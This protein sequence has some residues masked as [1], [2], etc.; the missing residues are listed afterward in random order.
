MRLQAHNFCVFR[1]ILCFFFS[2]ILLLALSLSLTGQVKQMTSTAVQW[3]WLYMWYLFILFILS[4]HTLLI[5]RMY[6]TRTFNQSSNSLTECTQYSSFIFRISNNYSI[7]ITIY[8]KDTHRGNGEH[9]CKGQA[10]ERGAFVRTISDLIALQTMTDYLCC[11]ESKLQHEHGQQIALSV[12]M[13]FWRFFFPWIPAD[14][15]STHCELCDHSWCCC[16]CC[17]CFSLSLSLS[18]RARCW[19]RCSS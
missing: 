1:A 4:H 10:Y 6:W 5:D 16:Y 15:W 2:S 12:R 11:I 14:F 7:I 3:Q 13:L 19:R 18:G 17:G 9:D 8:L